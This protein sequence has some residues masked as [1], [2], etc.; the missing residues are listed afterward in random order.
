MSL[1]YLLG[2]MH[3]ATERK[4]TLR[5]SQKGED[6]PL[7]VRDMIRRLGFSAWIYREGRDR[8]VYVVEF[9]KSILICV[10]PKSESEMADYIRGY[11]DAEGS[12]PRD[13]ESRPYIYLAQKDRRDLS[14]LKSFLTSL[15][16]ECGKIHN[17]SVRVDS[18]YWRFYIK[19][20]SL[21]RFAKMIGSS[22]PRKKHIIKRYSELTE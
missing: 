16:I 2:L 7:L 6:F 20:K 15:G 21:P 13:T 3:D 17:P 22:H 18:D 1:S 5:F 19:R 8:D 9:S 14:Q 11:F 12:V 10:T 4:Y